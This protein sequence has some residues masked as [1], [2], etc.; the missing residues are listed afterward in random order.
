MKLRVVLFLFIFSTESLAEEIRVEKRMAGENL[1]LVLSQWD[2]IYELYKYI[3]NSFPL[4]LGVIEKTADKQKVIYFHEDLQSLPS[5]MKISGD[6][7]YLLIES[8]NLKNKKI[9][10]LKSKEEIFP[11]DIEGN[12][13]TVF[14]NRIFIVS[15]DELF[16]IID[17][18]RRRIAGLNPV[19][20]TNKISANNEALYVSNSEGLFK[21]NIATGESISVTSTIPVWFEAEE[22]G[23]VLF[24]DKNEIK[25]WNSHNDESVYFKSESEIWFIKRNSNSLILID[26]NIVIILDGKTSSIQ[27]TNDNHFVNLRDAV[28]SNGTIILYYSDNVPSIVRSIRKRIRLHPRE[29]DKECLAK[30]FK[31]EKIGSEVIFSIVNEDLDLFYLYKEINEE[32]IRKNLF[33]LSLLEILGEDGFEEAKIIYLSLKP[34]IPDSLNNVLIDGLRKISPLQT[35]E[36]IK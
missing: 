30:L 6:N 21:I 5:D 33:A 22:S 18:E 36:L 23:G 3:P 7:I 12:L 19:L 27:F 35:E 24:L 4:F 2:K 10:E 29:A 11:G 26:E 14:N 34:L 16:E 13:W 25:K 17:G 15:G 9:I 1:A 32:I 28:F 8:L 20:R 31:E